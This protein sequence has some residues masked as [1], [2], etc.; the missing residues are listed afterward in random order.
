M[1]YQG[2]I[3]KSRTYDFA[4]LKAVSGAVLMGLPQ[5]SDSFNTFYYGLAFLAISAI[6][7]FLRHKTTGPVGEK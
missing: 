3:K 5:V 2:L 1:K 7:G 6:D 4:A